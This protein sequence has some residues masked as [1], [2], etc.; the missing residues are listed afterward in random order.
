M[1]YRVPDT[2]GPTDFPDAFVRPTSC[3]QLVTSD[4]S[5][6]SVAAPFRCSGY[7]RVRE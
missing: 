1:R 3:G 5:A 7:A 4:G 2:L 6:F